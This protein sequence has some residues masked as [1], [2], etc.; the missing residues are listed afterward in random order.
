MPLDNTPAGLFLVNKLACRLAISIFRRIINQEY[1]GIKLVY[2]T[3]CCFLVV[4]FPWGDQNAWDGLMAEQ[5]SSLKI[6]PTE[7]DN[8]LFCCMPTEVPL[9]TLFYLSS[10]SSIR[11]RSEYYSVEMSC[12]N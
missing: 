4:L 7:V 3:G 6:L 9:D 2:I 1:T 5:W 11:L 10:K 8:M 12:T